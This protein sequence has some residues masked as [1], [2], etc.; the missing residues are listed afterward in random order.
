MPETTL[1]TLQ[2][3]ASIAKQGSELVMDYSIDYKELDGIERFGAFALAQFTHFLKEPLI[4]A[5]A[6]QDLHQHIEKMGYVVLEDLSG[7][8]ITERYF[9]HRADHIRHTHASHLIHLKL[10]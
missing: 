3:I 7:L 8:D 4:G 9:H 2:D 1:S 5:F 10:L 6:S